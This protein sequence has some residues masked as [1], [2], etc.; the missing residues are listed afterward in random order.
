[1]RECAQLG[2]NHVWMH[3]SVGTGSESASA[4]KY[5]R[6]QGITVIRSARS[7]R[8]WSGAMFATS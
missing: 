3:R 5:G 7:S 1:M 6:E 2:I 8:C 4:T